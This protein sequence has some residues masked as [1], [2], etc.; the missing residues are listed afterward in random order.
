MSCNTNEG[1]SPLVVFEGTYAE[2]LFIKMLLEAG[3]IKTA[4]QE[5][6]VVSLEI[7]SCLWRVYVATVDYTQAE[8][9]VNH[10]RKHGRRTE[11]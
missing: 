9:A 10:F 7:G 6:S 5:P 1:D 3:G 11:R 4:F 8:E 2:A